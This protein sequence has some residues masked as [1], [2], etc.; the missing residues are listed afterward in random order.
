MQHAWVEA[1]L[2]REELKVYVALGS[3]YRI[4]CNQVEVP[5][6]QV[7]AESHVAGIRFRSWQPWSSLHPTIPAHAPLVFDVYDRIAGRSVGG[8]KYHVAHQGGRAH[9]TRPINDLEAEGRRR[10][11]F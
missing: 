1:A 4:T 7:G 9:E 2:E 11:R 6:T 8:L 3:R 5:L 10:V